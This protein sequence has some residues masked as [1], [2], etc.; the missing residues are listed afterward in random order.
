WQDSQLED[1]DDPRLPENVS[2]TQHDLLFRPVV[3]AA[4]PFSTF[5]ALTV[6]YRLPR[7]GA[8]RWQVV[9]AAAEIWSAV[10]LDCAAGLLRFKVPGVVEDFATL[11]QRWEEWANYRDLLR[12]GPLRAYLDAIEQLLSD[13]WQEC[14]DT[15]EPQAH[16][17]LSANLRAVCL[18]LLGDWQRAIA[19]WERLDEPEAEHNLGQI[20]LARGRHLP[21]VA[22]MVRLA[23]A[24]EEFRAAHG[25]YPPQ[26]ESLV[27]R[28]LITVPPGYVYRAHRDRFSLRSA[29]AAYPRW[30]PGLGVL[31]REGELPQGDLDPA[32]RP[33]T[34]L[35]AV[36]GRPPR[37]WVAAM[38]ESQH[39]LEGAAR[40][41]SLDSLERYLLKLRMGHSARLERVRRIDD[42]EL[43]RPRFFKAAATLRK[44]AELRLPLILKLWQLGVSQLVRYLCP[45]G[46]Q[47]SF[48][49]HALRT[50]ILQN[51]AERLT[52]LQEKPLQKIIPELLHDGCLL[53]AAI[54]IESQPEPEWLAMMGGYYGLS[55]Y[56]TNSWW[57][58]WRR[59]LGEPVELPWLETLDFEADQLDLLRAAL[60]LRQGSPQAALDCLRDH[61]DPRAGLLR[62]AARR[63]PGQ[64]GLE[65]AILH[66]FS[67]WGE[68]DFWAAE[69]ALERGETDEV[70]KLLRKALEARPKNVRYRARLVWL[71]RS[72]DRGEEAEAHLKVLQFLRPDLSDPVAQIMSLPRVPLLPPGYR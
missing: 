72:L 69:L 5:A 16:E 29:R 40:A 23:T 34:P 20:R 28:H 64:R 3:A 38:R 6:P 22:E 47:A 57:Q 19:L 17:P 30:Q 1:F 35:E 10:S 27:P 45:A 68:A 8:K 62:L 33:H 61:Q 46:D 26:L 12:A 53:E 49:T 31:F 15:L 70:E 43:I 9:P 25:F 65:L 18:A 41:F 71:L 66:G 59:V 37:L 13:G 2:L 32:R 4:G 67:G 24:I 55:G 60:F 44:H 51:K 36:A 14:L 50:R 63:D 52:V 48:A 58:A 7:L 42:R 54:G 39:D 56:T 21:V 11:Q